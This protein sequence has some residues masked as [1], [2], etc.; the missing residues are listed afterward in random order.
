MVHPVVVKPSTLRM[1]L[2]HIQN[3]SGVR[4]N[5]NVEIK[6]RVADLGLM[7]ER[8]AAIADGPESIDQTDTFFKCVS[9]RFKLR[10]F[11][12]ESGELI[13]Y[14][15]PDQPQPSTSRYSRVAVRDPDRLVELLQDALGVV[16]SV[17]KRRELWLCGRTR[18][19]LDL[20]EGLGAFLELEVVL[21]EHENEAKGRA[22][23]QA[24]LEL[25]HVH[26]D[27]LLA[28][29]YLDLLARRVD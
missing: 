10:V 1:G 23:A 2:T 5:R 11:G 12:D 13:Y 3:I 24:I 19:H 4:M 14:E 18:I 8:I 17:R 6:A 20:V 28:D 29:A 27:D 21:D 26:A 7:R 15:R 25:L 9:G 22:E 16:G